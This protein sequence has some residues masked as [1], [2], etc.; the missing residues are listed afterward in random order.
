[1]ASSVSQA[2]KKIFPLATAAIVCGSTGKDFIEGISDLDIIVIGP[3]KTNLDEKLT[4]LKRFSHD[5]DP[6]YITVNNLKNSLFCGRKPGE[7][8]ELHSFDLYRIKNQGQV[9]FGDPD[10]IKLFPDVT[11]SQALHDTLPYVRDIFIKN[12]KVKKEIKDINLFIVIMREIYTI[13]TQQYGSKTSSFE[14]LKN[15]YPQFLKLV[16]FVEDTYLQK[17]PINT[18]TKIEIS[19]F[20]NFAEQTIDSYFSSTSSP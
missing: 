9:L 4:N 15:K 8:Y 12:L 1:M 2:I 5:I 18:I 14:Y 16:D 11:I 7:D 3:K 20:L 6:M 10:T 17:H 19:D 13:E